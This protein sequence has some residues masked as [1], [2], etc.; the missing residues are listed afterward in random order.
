MNEYSG[1]TLLFVVSSVVYW[2]YVSLGFALFSILDHQPL[3]DFLISAQITLPITLF[4]L[5]SIS[6]LSR[7]LEFARIETFAYFAKFALIGAV[8]PVAFTLILDANEAYFTGVGI[9]WSV[10]L[11]S[12]VLGALNG[13]LSGYVSRCKSERET[14]NTLFPKRLQTIG[15]SVV[16][17]LALVSVYYFGWEKFAPGTC[18]QRSEKDDVWFVLEHRM[19]TYQLR[20]WLGGA[21][22]F[23][24]LD[25]DE[26][27]WGAPISMGRNHVERTHPGYGALECP[28]PVPGHNGR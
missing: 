18:V 5:L 17:M 11:T 7:F 8:G 3:G 26:P 27:H 21:Y 19:G 25:P 4:S 15:G 28:K 22:N 20:K 12:F 1:R 6:I 24:K 10:Q 16:V 23:R 13:L 14:Q 2:L 9:S